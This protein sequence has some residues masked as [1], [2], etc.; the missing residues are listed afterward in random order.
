MS[1]FD[2]LQR[3]GIV[4]IGGAV[5]VAI[6]SSPRS[7]NSWLSAL[8]RDAMELRAL[9]IHN[10]LDVETLPERCVLQLHW[11]REPNFQKFLSRHNFRT[12]TIARHPL[13]VLISV[14]HF[15]RYEPET[16]KWLGGNC[17]L[18]QSLAEGSP[19]SGA[20]LDYAVSFGSENLLS[21]TYQWWRD[22]GAIKVRYEDLVAAPEIEVAQIAER[23]YMSGARVI[24]AVLANSFATFKDRPNRHGWQGRPGLWQELIPHEDACAIFARHRTIFETLGYSLERTQLTRASAERNWA[25]LLR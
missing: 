10:Y 16:A 6:V 4:L 11:Y 8:L 5:R 15:V 7:G 17:E 20:F 14:L 23:L 19:T 2:P 3:C 1:A 24:D 13:D 9:A 22:P 12:I 25:S 21:V 18:S